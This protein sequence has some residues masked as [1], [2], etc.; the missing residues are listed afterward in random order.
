MIEPILALMTFSSLLA[1][2]FV[3]GSRWSWNEM[4]EICFEQV[5]GT[6]ITVTELKAFHGGSLK[7]FSK[8]LV[9]EHDRHIAELIVKNPD[10]FVEAVAH[11]HPPELDVCHDFIEEDVEYDCDG[12]SGSTFSCT[13]C[14]TE[15]PE[16]GEE[17]YWQDM[18][19]D[20]MVDAAIER[21]RMGE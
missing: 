1:F 18:W 5:N 17:G 8:G 21:R 9:L 12:P 4:H 19:E 16:L 20:M 11:H 14:A 2:S 6:L 10:V 15:F 13:I 3:E 7:S